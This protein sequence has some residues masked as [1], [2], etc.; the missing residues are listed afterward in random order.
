LVRRVEPGHELRQLDLA[1][2]R[3]GEV[4]DRFGLRRVGVLRSRRSQ[5]DEEQDE[6][7]WY[8]CRHVAFR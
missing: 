1:R 3:R 5:C 4:F 6:R 8:Q 2:D 7:R